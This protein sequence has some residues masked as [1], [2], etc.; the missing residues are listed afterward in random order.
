[1]EGSDGAFY[2]TTDGGGGA[3][4]GTVFK[5]TS[6]GVLTTLATFDGTAGSDP[7]GSPVFGTD[8][9]L[10]GTAQ[11]MTIWRLNLAASST[12]APAVTNARATA[13]TPAGATLNATV[14]SNGAATDVLFQ[15]STD[16]TLTSGVMTTSPA[17]SLGSGAPSTAVSAAV[18]GLAAHTTYYF[19]ARATNAVGA[20]NGTIYP[21][22][23]ETR[24][25]LLRAV[26]L[27][28]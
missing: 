11:Q 4:S 8:G 21:L 5:V 7:Q 9:N 17:Q 10:Y 18:T 22:P 14:G 2:G 28:P 13:I 19:R 27:R 25:R 16:A 24:H 6:A 20:T 3:W 23:P 12:A 15:Y 1:V 26:L